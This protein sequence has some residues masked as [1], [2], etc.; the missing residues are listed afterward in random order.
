MKILTCVPLFV[1][2]VCSE[3]GDKPADRAPVGTLHSDQTNT[4]ETIKYFASLGSDKV[5]TIKYFASLRSDKVKT[6]KYYATL[7]SDI[8]KAIK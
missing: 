1:C 5:K 7:G 8:V 6:I 4:V 2:L 3:V